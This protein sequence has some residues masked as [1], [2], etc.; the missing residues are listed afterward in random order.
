MRIPCYAQCEATPEKAAS[1]LAVLESGMAALA[2]KSGAR[3][4]LRQAV[5]EGCSRTAGCEKSQSH[6]DY[7]R[8]AAVD[9][10]MH[11]QQ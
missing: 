5:V 1:G 7:E 4:W 6:G 9:A 10:G 8:K 3:R 11:G 2:S